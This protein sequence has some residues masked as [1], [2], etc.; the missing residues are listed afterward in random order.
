MQNAERIDP[1]SALGAL[2]PL[3]ALD[4]LD[5]YGSRIWMFYKDVCLQNIHTILALMRANQLGFV[6]GKVIS[7]AI[8]NHGDGLDIPGLLV[9]VKDRLPAFQ[10]D[11]S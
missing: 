7:R 3:F 5:R 1:D 2:T 10:I 8:D 11:A 4:N 9:R 6:S